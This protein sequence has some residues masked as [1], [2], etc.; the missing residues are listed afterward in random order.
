MTASG[1]TCFRDLATCEVSARVVDQLCQDKLRSYSLS[2]AKHVKAVISNVMT[3]AMQAGAVETNPARQ[4]PPD[5][6]PGE[7][8][9]EEGP[10]AHR[11]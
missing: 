2:T 4:I 8:Q 5:R 1:I 3:F 7:E 9:A 11:S 6:A 10:G